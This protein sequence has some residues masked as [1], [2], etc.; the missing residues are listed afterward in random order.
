MAEFADLFEKSKL[1]I[2]NAIPH[3]LGEVPDPPKHP[4]SDPR[5]A[6]APPGD[7]HSAVRLDG[8]LQNPGG[9]GDDPGKLLRAVQLQTQGHPEPVPQRGGQLARPVVAPMR[10]NLGRSS[11]M[12]LAEGPLP[13]MMSMA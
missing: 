13:M 2:D 9:A 4:V 1:L 6:P 12:E 3:H 8:D 11:R 7:L 5:G 10:V